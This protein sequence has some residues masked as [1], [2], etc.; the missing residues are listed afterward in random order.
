MVCC[1]EWKVFYGFGLRVEVTV[2]G[3]KKS[4]RLFGDSAN[5]SKNGSEKHE[6]CYILRFKQHP[7]FFCFVLHT[8]HFHLSQNSVLVSTREPKR[9]RY[10]LFEIS[11]ELQNTAETVE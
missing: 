4:V 10:M 9:D 6:Y 11:L 1:R 8:Y 3:S 5:I 7:I 2:T